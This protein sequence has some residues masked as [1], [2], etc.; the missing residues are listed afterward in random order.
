MKLIK[1]LLIILLVFSLG[2]GAYFFANNLLSNNRLHTADVIPADAIFVF[3]TTEPVE[4]WNQMVS[5]PLWSR[6]RDIPSLQGLENK[7]LALDSLAGRGGKLENSLSGNKFSVSLHQSAKNEVDFLF[8]ISFPGKKH[9][10]FIQSLTNKIDSKDIRS[11]NYSGVEISEYAQDGGPLSFALIDNL[12][13]GSYSSFLLEDA[14]RYSQSRELKSFKSGSSVLYKNEP[15]PSGIGILRLSSGGIAKFIQGLSKGVE[16]KELEYFSTNKLEANLA[17]KLVDD[18]IIFQGSAFFSDGEKVNIQWNGNSKQ[19]AFSNYVSNRTAVFHRYNVMDP[20]QIQALPNPGFEETSTLKGEM[21]QFFPEDLFYR[22]LTGEVGLMILEES[23]TSEKE[24]ILLLKT[25]EVDK[26]VDLLK[27]F[28]WNLLGKDSEQLEQDVYLGKRI[29]GIGAEEFPAHIFEGQFIGFPRTYISSYDHMIIMGSSLKAVRVFLDDIYNDNTWGKS[30]YHKRFLE[31]LSNDSGYEF[32]LSVARSWT[33]VIGTASPE[34]KVFFQKYA[35]QVK[36]VEWIVLQQ[37]G[38]DTQIEFQYRLEDIK[39]NTDIILAENMSAVFDTKLTYGPQAIQ[40]F[41]DRSTDYLVQDEQNQVHLVT[42][43][44]DIIFSHLVD[45]KIVGDVFQI[46][47]YKNNKLQLLFATTEALYGIDRFGVI[48]PGYP[49]Y[50]PSGEQISQ[51]NL[52]DYEQD[53]EYRYFV[54]TGLGDLFLFDKSGNLL[55]GWAPRHTS[56]RLA[57]TPA[58]HRI[59]RV[60][61]FM[62]AVN[63]SGELYLMNRKGELKSGNPLKIGNGI[64]TEYAIVGTS[65]ASDSQLVTIDQDGEVVNVNFNGEVTYRNQLLRPDRDTRFHL[66]KDQSNS[67]HLFVVHEYNKISVLNAEE[68]LLFEKGIYSDDLEFQFFSFGGGKNIFVMIDK[69]QGFIYLYNFQGQLLN[70]R[71][72]NGGQNIEISYSGS[73]NEY[74]ILV[75]HD[76]QLSGFKMPL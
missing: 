54:G 49:I 14:I 46:D 62:V 59:A 53:L 10:E 24:R 55:E 44:G 72:I 19:N 33:E 35:P 30:I 69:V 3:E 41:N 16:L 5:Q 21:D 2:L 15:E 63:V 43:E 56:G 75:I 70:T 68:E 7:L 37:K 73:N 71:P 60:G 1:R 17:L 66:V 76:K 11:R 23:G 4:A 12:L 28:N 29:F 47:F 74:S 36:A 51:V 57:T 31:Y 8:S 32:V 50:L 45:G 52:V 18:K 67:S 22:R 20:F 58:H 34:W 39:P 9:R 13:L 64:S 61:D 27:E 26:Q 6:L 48:L 40:N 42:E 38:E 25:S 65:R